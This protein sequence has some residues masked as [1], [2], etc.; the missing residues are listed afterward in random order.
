M[1]S[2]DKKYYIRSERVIEKK[3]G[4][5]VALYDE[6][7]RSIHVLN[8]TARFIWECLKKPVTFDEILFMMNEVFDFETET[9]KNDL[10]ETLTLFKGKNL[11]ETRGG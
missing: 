7:N 5:D 9:L 8:P 1:T 6:E 10:E 4:K 2:S 3:V 11:F